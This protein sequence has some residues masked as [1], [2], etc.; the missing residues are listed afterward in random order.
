MKRENTTRRKRKKKDYSFLYRG[1]PDFDAVKKKRG[2]KKRRSPR[3]AGK[4]R[5]GL[6]QPGDRRRKRRGGDLIPPLWVSKGKG[7]NLYRSKGRNCRHLRRTQREKGGEGVHHLTERG[8]RKEKHLAREVSGRR[9][10]LR[11]KE[12]TDRD[13]QKKKKGLV[14]SRRKKGGETAIDRKAFS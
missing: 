9:G 11:R 12:G 7:K 10:K 2:R 3:A 4:K 5:R 13:G 8:E 6:G 14:P 1:D